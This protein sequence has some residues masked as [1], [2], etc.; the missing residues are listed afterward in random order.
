V[1]EQSFQVTSTIT[2]DFTKKRLNLRLADEWAEYVTLYNCC[3]PTEVTIVNTA[4][5]HT[6]GGNLSIG[7]PVPNTNV[8]ILDDDENP[9]PIGSVGVMWAGGH[10]VSRGYVNLPELTSQKFKQDKFANDG[11]A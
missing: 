9:L 2:F 1:S 4:K 7:K 3:G 11:Y 6:S 10:C 8:Y 5:Q